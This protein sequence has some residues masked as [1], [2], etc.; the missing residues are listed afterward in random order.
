MT[1]HR[2]GPCVNPEGPV[3]CQAGACGECEVMERRKHPRYETFAAFKV[4]NI[5][6]V[7]AEYRHDPTPVLKKESGK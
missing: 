5:R 6:R 7:A 1:N 4:R 2:G 3:T